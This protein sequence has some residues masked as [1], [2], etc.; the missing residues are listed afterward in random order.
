MRGC[1]NCQEEVLTQTEQVMGNT[2]C[3]L[4]MISESP[5]YAG[6]ESFFQI[7]LSNIQVQNIPEYANF[8]SLYSTVS[9]SNCAH[10]TAKITKDTRSVQR[11]FLIKPDF[12]LLPL[13]KQALKRW[14]LGATRRLFSANSCSNVS[15][16][17]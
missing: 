5:L 6:A 12:L 3:R 1:G 4:Y 9:L 16:W 11:K 7:N 14:Y 13:C 10:V 8:C 15:E 17:K 2:V